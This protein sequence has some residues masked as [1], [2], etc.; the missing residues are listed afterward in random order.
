MPTAAQPASAPADATTSSAPRSR[1]TVHHSPWVGVIV[2]SMFAAFA[3]T[4]IVPAVLRSQGRDGNEAQEL[5]SKALATAIHDVPFLVTLPES[6]PGGAKLVRVFLDKPDYEQGFQ[7]F[8][9]NTYYA[10]PG[11]GTTASR[12]IHVW[13]TNDP[14]LARNP[15]GDPTTR[16]VP[17]TIAGRTWTRVVDNRLRDHAPVTAFS[18]RYDGDLTIAVDAIDP[19][20]A[21]ATIEAL[22]DVPKGAVPGGVDVDAFRAALPR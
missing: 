4:M 10:A 22:V 5:A 11:E 8:T 13:Q 2:F 14:F 7:V 15:G 19:D 20:Q 9:L 17:E 16:G 12:S 3:A 1:A 18:T 6:L 21:R